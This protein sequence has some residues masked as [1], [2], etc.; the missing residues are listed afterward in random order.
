[1]LVLWVCLV[2]LEH[3]RTEPSVENI[4]MLAPEEHKFI[5]NLGHKGLLWH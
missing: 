3:V 1:M 5:L 4:H 2:L